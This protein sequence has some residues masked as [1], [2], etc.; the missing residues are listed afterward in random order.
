MRGC[1]KVSVGSVRSRS[2]LQEVDPADARH[3]VPREVGPDRRRALPDARL[4][5]TSRRGRIAEPHSVGKVGASRLFSR[6]AG[7]HRAEARV[8]QSQRSHHRSPSQRQR[9]CRGGDVG[10]EGDEDPLHGQKLPEAPRIGKVAPADAV[11]TPEPTRCAD[12]THSALAVQVN[13]PHHPA[14][15]CPEEDHHAEPTPTAPALDPRFCSFCA[16]PS[17]SSAAS[18]PT[19]R[20]PR[21]ARRSSSEPRRR[22]QRKR[23][24]SRLPK[25]TSCPSRWTPRGST[26]QRSRSSPR[27]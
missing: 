3:G 23:P 15:R 2:I 13:A 19:R 18:T 20:R 27:S 8:G 21:R 26:R 11:D 5:H 16:A 14:P 22:R 4:Q 25:R 7:D 9:L 24:R 10:A 17:A 6:S 12:A 1:G